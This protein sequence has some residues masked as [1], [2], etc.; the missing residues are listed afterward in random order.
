MIQKYVL[1][2]IHKNDSFNTYID[3]IDEHTTV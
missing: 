2:S 1:Y 3:K